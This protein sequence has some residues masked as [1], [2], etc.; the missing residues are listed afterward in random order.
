VA[1]APPEPGAAAA[2]PQTRRAPPLHPLIAAAAAGTLPDWAR[3]SPARRDH[4]ARVA[5]LMARWAAALRLP[6][7][8]RDRWVAAAWLHDTLRDASPAELLPLAPP[9]LRDAPPALL[10]GPAAARRLADAGVDDHAILDAVAFHTL[11]HQRLDR[12]GRHLYLADFLEPGREF[13]AAERAALRARVPDASPDVLRTVVRLRLGHLLDEGSPIRA[14]TIGFWNDVAAA[15][16]DAR[17][18]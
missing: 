17:P 6:A 12:L 9:P 3:V 10:H 15:A 5:A 16:G 2:A 4:I 1:G 13:L 18:D 7:R 11:G 8:D 14:E